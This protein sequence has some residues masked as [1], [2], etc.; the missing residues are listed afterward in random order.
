MIIKC[1]HVQFCGK[2]HI[3]V[4]WENRAFISVSV[5]IVSDRTVSTNICLSL[6]HVPSVWKRACVEQRPISVFFSWC[7]W[8][9]VQWTSPFLSIQYSPVQCME[10]GVGIPTRNP[11]TRQQTRSLLLKQKK[12]NQSLTDF[13]RNSTTLL[14]LNFEVRLIFRRAAKNVASSSSQFWT[15]RSW[16]HPARKF[17]GIFSSSHGGQ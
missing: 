12:K 16:F 7:S 1:C 8:R 14:G 6:K 15:Y 10:D 3:R 2:C 5:R 11:Q 9:S 17:N 4:I 13:R